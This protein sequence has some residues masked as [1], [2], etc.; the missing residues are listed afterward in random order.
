MNSKHRKT[1]E[2]IFSEPVPKSLEWS[3]IE[4]L[5]VAL[6]ASIIEGEGSRVRF[7]LNEVVASFHR[8]HPSK[9][10]K[11]YQVRDARH[12]LEQAGVTP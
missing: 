7:L 11:P 8:P 6:G 12:F 1:L 4:S 2:A 5:F 10:A 3:R 9:E